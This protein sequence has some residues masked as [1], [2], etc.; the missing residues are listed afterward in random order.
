[1][2]FNFVQPLHPFV[3]LKSEKKAKPNRW[4]RKVFAAHFMIAK[5]SHESLLPVSFEHEFISF[6]DAEDEFVIKFYYAKT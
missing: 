2:L 5:C 1:M 4:S 6:C 3:R